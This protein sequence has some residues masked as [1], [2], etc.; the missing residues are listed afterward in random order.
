MVRV[1]KKLLPTGK[2][3]QQSS[4]VIPGIN[5]YSPALSLLANP[6]CVP[7]Q[8]KGEDGQASRLW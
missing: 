4:G 3:L 6:G 2:Q 1:R 7:K 5:E 8:T